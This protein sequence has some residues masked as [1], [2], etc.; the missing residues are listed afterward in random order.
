[1]STSTLKGT[2]FDWLCALLL[3]VGDNLEDSLLRYYLLEAQWVLSIIEKDDDICCSSS[4]PVM[5]QVLR[6]DQNLT[7]LVHSSNT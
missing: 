1:M 3:R 6:R 5:K 7:H 2:R 4:L